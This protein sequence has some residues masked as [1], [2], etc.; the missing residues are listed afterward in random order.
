M[1]LF[2]LRLLDMG[3]K[4]AVLPFVVITSHVISF[5]EFS[6]IGMYC[7]KTKSFT[8]GNIAISFFFSDFGYNA[9]RDEIDYSMSKNFYDA[10]KNLALRLTL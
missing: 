2:F 7:I 1:A 8:W 6:Y 3:H 10:C 4:C 5:R 9:E